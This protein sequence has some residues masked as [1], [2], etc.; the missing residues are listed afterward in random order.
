MGDIK[1][2]FICKRSISGEPI[3]N[4]GTFVDDDELNNRLSRGSIKTE[5]VEEWHPDEDGIARKC[6]KTVYIEE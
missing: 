2:N 1:S 5:T 6:Y 4:F 3:T